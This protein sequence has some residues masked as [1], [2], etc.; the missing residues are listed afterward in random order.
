[1]HRIDTTDH[2][3]RW[4]Y[5]CPEC[6]SNDWRAN[7]GNFDCRACGAKPAGLIDTK[8][9]EFIPRQEI[10]FIGPESSWKAPYAARRPESD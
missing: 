1:M 10:V 4:R 9:A 3:Q 2:S 6:E 8:E 7:N 5:E